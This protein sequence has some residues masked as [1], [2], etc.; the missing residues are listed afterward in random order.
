MLRHPSHLLPIVPLDPRMATRSPA[1]PAEHHATRRRRRFATHC[2]PSGNSFANRAGRPPSAASCAGS[3]SPPSTRICSS[4][5]PASSSVVASRAPSSSAAAKGAGIERVPR[6]I[7]SLPEFHLTD[8]Q[9]E[10]LHLPI[11]LVFFVH[12][13][14]AQRVLAL[15]P[16]PAGAVESLLTLE[17]WQTLV[18]RQSR[19]GR[20]RAGRGGPSGQPDEGCARVLPHADRRVFQAGRLDPGPLARAF[21]RHE[22]WDEVGRFFAELGRA[23]AHRDEESRVLDLNFT[24][25]R[26]EPQPHAAAPLLIFKLRIAETVTAEEPTTIP[27]IALRCQIR[28]E[29]TRRRYEP[30]EEE[31]LL[32]LFGEPERWGQTL[33]ST[34]WTH[35]SVVVPPFT[36]DTLSISPSPARSTSMWRRPSTS[37][38]SKTARSRSACSSAARSFT[39]TKT[40]IS[41]SARSPGKKR[42]TFRLPVQVWKDMM[43]LYYPN[44]AWLCLE[45]DTFDRLYRFKSGRGL[46][47][48]G[49]GDRAHCSIPAWRR[50]NHEPG[51][52][53]PDRRAPCFTRATSFTRIA[54]R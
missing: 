51:T 50:S 9:W 41:R 3:R 2:R 25:E 11:N 21:G 38:R 5:R 29:P 20:A 17:A 27:A 28:I 14:P 24:V 18:D 10:D 40:D 54:P 6:D 42:R 4:R 53:R 16:S 49:A 12:S 1:L 7:W 33:R 46:A 52:R 47:D 8:I 48:L 26:A 15:Y 34:L 37:T 43:E 35:A 31:K 22:V 13:T 19:A 36:G 39:P 44:S 32:D 23:F 30:G 45:R